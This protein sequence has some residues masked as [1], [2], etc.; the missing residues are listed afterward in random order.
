M[1]Y[2]SYAF[3]NILNNS[4]LLKLSLFVTHQHNYSIFLV[5]IDLLRHNIFCL[6][7]Y[8]ILAKNI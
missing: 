2:I 5:F 6:Y 4:K 3:D 8:F 7:Q 1:N